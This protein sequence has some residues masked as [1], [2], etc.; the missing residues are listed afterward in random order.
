MII[1]RVLL[2]ICTI[3]CRCFFL[4]NSPNI[5]AVVFLYQGAKVKTFLASSLTNGS[6]IFILTIS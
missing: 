2:F 1:L 3:S 5:E 4:I 6:I